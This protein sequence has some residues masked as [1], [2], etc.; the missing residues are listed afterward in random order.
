MAAV[1]LALDTKTL[2]EAMSVLELVAEQVDIV[3]AGTVL[4][5]SEGLGSISSLRD[6][7]PNKPI[8]ADI[9]IGR[10]G[11][12]FAE[13][14]IANGADIVTVLAEAPKDVLA[15]ALAAASKAGKKVEVEL[16][17]GMPDEKI[18]EIVQENPSGIIVHNRAGG[19]AET[20]PW[21]RDTLSLLT[22]LKNG[23]EISLAGGL[24]ADRVAALD[25]NWAIDVLVVGSEVTRS[26]DPRSAIRAIIDSMNSSLGNSK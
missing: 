3:E 19:S 1:Q 8:V 14:A 26:A 21:I 4:C 25:S 9:R 12:M 10:A 22:K 5:L 7:A 20:D 15:G 16:P 2:R 11:A 17:F 13:L 6:L 18:R 23:F 24:S